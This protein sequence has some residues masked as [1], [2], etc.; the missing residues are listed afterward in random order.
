MDETLPPER[1]CRSY[2]R[3]PT[4]VVCT[5]KCSEPAVAADTFQRVFIASTFIGGRGHTGLFAPNLD[6]RMIRSIIKNRLS[7]S[8]LKDMTTRTHLTM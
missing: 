1:L 8:V 7:N 2:A 5:L 4:P 3:Y 6:Q